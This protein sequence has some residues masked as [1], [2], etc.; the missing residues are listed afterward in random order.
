[1]EK[2][3][4]SKVSQ[5]AKPAEDAGGLVLPVEDEQGFILDLEAANDAIDGRTSAAERSSPQEGPLLKSD[6]MDWM[7]SD[8]YYPALIHTLE[9]KIADHQQEI[10]R[11]LAEK[12][13]L[14]KDYEDLR[15]I[16][17]LKGEELKRAIM[18]IFAKYWSLEAASM[19]E[20]RRDGF[21]ENIL[22]EHD[23]RKILAKVKGT[24]RAQP[25]PKF[26]TQLWQDLHYSGLGISADG[27]LIINYDVRR[28]PKN[29]AL[30]YAGEDEEQLQDIILIDTR[31]LYKLT[32]AIIDY[33]LPLVEATRRLFAKGRVEYDRDDFTY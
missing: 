5:D 24:S 26:I 4:T 31:S 28:D 11:L 18:Q 32:I 23:D 19:D 30:A 21:K 8:D 20:T 1:M 2:K 12:E 10:E 7:N 15:G 6:N 9:K 13:Q 22:I 16:L 3:L 27:A 25:S 33:N 29:R 14:I 17:Y